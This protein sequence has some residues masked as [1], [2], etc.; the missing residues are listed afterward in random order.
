M[1]EDMLRRLGD[2]EVEWAKDDK[3]LAL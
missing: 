1:S 3:L 2:V